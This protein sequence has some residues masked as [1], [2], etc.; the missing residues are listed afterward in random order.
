MILF[1][2]FSLV[3]SSFVASS[4]FEMEGYM[5]SRISPRPESSH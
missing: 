2:T 4:S 1:A 5:Y 3:D